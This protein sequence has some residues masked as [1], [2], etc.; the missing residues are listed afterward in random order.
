MTILPTKKERLVLSGCGEKLPDFD[1]NCKKFHDF[2][3]YSQTFANIN[4]FQVF[5]TYILSKS[6][7]L[8]PRQS[9][10]FT[11]MYR[12]QPHSLADLEVSFVHKRVFSQKVISRLQELCGYTPVLPIISLRYF[13]AMLLHVYNSSYLYK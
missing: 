13:N 7:T 3:R 5:P 10:Y 9:M 12:K 2:S 6:A 4:S 8:R 11:C 1:E